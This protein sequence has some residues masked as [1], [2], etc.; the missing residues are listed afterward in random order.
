MSKKIVLG[1]LG[2]AIIIIFL[3]IVFSP[4]NKSKIDTRNLEATVLSVDNNYITLQSND[5][6]IY[7]FEKEDIT[8]EVGDSIVLEYMGLLDKSKDVQ[9]AKIISYQVVDVKSKNNIPA[10]YDDNGI[11]STYYVMAYDKLKELS[12]DEKIGQLLLV[13]YDANTALTDL[14]TYNFGGFVFFA[15]DFKDKTKDQVINMITTLQNN[16]KIPLLTAVDE[17]GGDVVRVSSNTNLRSFPFK[18]PKTL[19]D[20]GKFDLIKSDTIEKSNLLKSLGLNLNLAPVVD[21]TTN[22]DDYMYK[23]ALGEN[24]ATTSEYAKTV[25]EASKNSG[26][27]YTL[28]H[29]P[30]YGN[31]KD[32]HEGVSSDTRSLE[33]IKTNDLPPFEAGINAG[34]E[35]VLVSHNIV[36]SIDP[37]N[38]ASLS[39][40]IHN[41]LRD[42]LKFTGIIMTDDIAM[43]AVTSIENTTLKAIQAGNDLIITTDYVKSF[44]EI[45]TSIENGTLSEEQIN[46]LAFRVL[47]WKYYKGLMVNLK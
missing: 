9:D 22:P 12:L 23:R 24:T 27:S 10:D 4:K 26:V 19:Y 45:K 31:N 1:I 34:A 21:V 28:K 13:R 41:L 43:G 20:D 11:F 38:P 40:N 32:T 15:K 35:A 29:F 3:I 36:T 33:D 16:S 47:S 8:L 42:D 2:I 14:N 46:K 30:G 5:N 18:S 44:N 6:I 37:D 17:E 7:T 25:I 39:K